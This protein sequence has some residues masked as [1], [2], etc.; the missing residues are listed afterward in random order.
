MDG[1]NGV[2]AKKRLPQRPN[3]PQ[4]LTLASRVL[5]FAEARNE[6]AGERCTAV[7]LGL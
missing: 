4:A 5:T 2:P 7:L 1:D 3:L 6:T